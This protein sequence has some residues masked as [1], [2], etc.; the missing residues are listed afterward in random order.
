ML[1][2]FDTRTDE[3]GT[4]PLADVAEDIRRYEVLGPGD[5]SAGISGGVGR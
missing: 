2:V 4:V 1:A 3:A 5:D